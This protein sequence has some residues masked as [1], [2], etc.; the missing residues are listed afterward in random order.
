[1]D[2]DVL[3]PTSLSEVKLGEL[4]IAH[5]PGLHVICGILFQSVSAILSG[6]MLNSLKCNLFP[7]NI[8]DTIWKRIPR[9]TCGPGI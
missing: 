3:S 1:M 5:T 9:F 4:E 8:A 6:K 7:G 2:T